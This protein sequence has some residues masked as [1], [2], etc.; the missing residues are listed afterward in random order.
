MTI[1]ALIELAVINKGNYTVKTTRIDVVFIEKGE[2]AKPTS[3]CSAVSS[4]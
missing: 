1:D 4:Y 2:I 3:M